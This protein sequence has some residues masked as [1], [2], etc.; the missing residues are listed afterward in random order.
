MAGRLLPNRF[1]DII[2]SI[3]LVRPGP[4]KSNMDKAYLPRR[5]GKEPVT[6]LHP[7]LKNALGETLGVILYQEQV[8]KVA[9]DLA[10]MSYAEADGF[11]RAMTHDRTE[12]EMEKM[13][14]A[15]IASATKNS[16][17]RKIAEKV[18]EQLA[19]FAAYGF[20]KAHAVAYATLAYQT[21]WLKCHYPAEFF[22]AVLSN[23]PMGY[24]PP[25]VL[26]ADAKRFG[27]KVLPPDINRSSSCYTLEDNAIRVSLRQL[28]GMSEEALKS[29]LSERDRGMFTSL[30]DFVLRTNVSQPILENLVRIGALDSFGSRGELLMQLPKLTELRHKIGRKTKPLFEDVRSETDL[31]EEITCV[32]RKARMQAE[33]ELLALT[34]SAHPLDFCTFDNKITKIKDLPSIATGK[35]VEIVGSVIRYQ[36][37][38]TRNGKRGS[39]L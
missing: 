38:P 9:H 15:F 14:D 28:K 20:C 3:S 12:E 8:L 7:R 25:R 11:R 17:S 22:A 2:V 33:R 29:I 34:L 16:V 10:G 27:V 31:L 18:F 24:Y 37:P 4:L 39:T 13:R 32:D 35:T 21:L 30:R 5:H 6:Y 36:T 19:A 1:E 23:Q 26:V